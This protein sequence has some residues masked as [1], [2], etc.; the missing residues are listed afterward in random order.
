MELSRRLEAIASLVDKDSKVF[1]VGCDHGYLAIYLSRNHEVVASDITSYAVDKTLEN[2]KKSKALNITVIKTDGLNNLDINK[3]DT[4]IVAGMGS[5]TIIKMLKDNKDKLPNTLIIE[6]NNSHSDLRT[7]LVELGY[8]MD[9]EVVVNDG[10]L[11]L[12]IKAKKGYRK[13]KDIDYLVGISN[14]PLYIKKVLK[15]YTDMYND[16][17]YKYIVKKIKTK[18]II[19]KIKLKLK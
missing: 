1:D 16:I 6:S 3:D 8:Y 19:D 18:L 13:Y 12:I 17:P 2:I 11:Y 9:K 14:D 10:K 4:V 15:R 5:Y 7:S